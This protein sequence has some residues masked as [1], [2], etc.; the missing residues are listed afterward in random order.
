MSH[1][2]IRITMSLML[3]SLRQFGLHGFP[4]FTCIEN[5]FIRPVHDE[6]FSHTAQLHV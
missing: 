2:N 3:H 4:G 5:L 6:E 1:I